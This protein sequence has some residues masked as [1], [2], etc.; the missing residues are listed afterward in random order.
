MSLPDGAAV[1][2]VC[3]GPDGILAHGRAGQTVV[4]HSTSPVK[5]TRGVAAAF[6]AKAID[7]ADAPV[8]R[9]RQAARAGTLSIMVGA[10]DA[11][12]RRIAPVLRFM[13]TE[14]THCGGVGAGQVVKLM[15]NMVLFQTVVALS[16]ALTI[17]RRAGVDGGVMLDCLS[18]G[19]ADSF[20][21][22]NH[23]KKALLPAEFPT[24][25]FPTRYALKDIAYALQLAADG[26]VYAAG[27]EL[28]QDLL[29]GAEEAGYGDN[30]FPALLHM[31]DPGLG[32]S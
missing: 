4:D 28:A 7:F 6:E 11:V 27:A 3:L 9:T 16:E 1:E 24:D 18:K 2:A 19:S 25:A 8:A 32:Q 30:Y 12:F 13:G 31:V 21:L 10:A 26:G 22:R 15:N 17:G 29:T 14:V 20:C 23:G 5:L